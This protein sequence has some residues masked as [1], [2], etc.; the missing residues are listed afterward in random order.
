MGWYNLGYAYFKQQQYSQ[1]VQAFQRYT[2]A[3]SNRAKP[4]SRAL[5]RVGDSYYF[6]R[7]FQEAERYYAQAADANP[8][9]ADYAAF[10]R[11]FVLGL[12]H[13]YQG[14][15]AALDNLMQ[16]YPNSQYFDDALYEEPIT[17]HAQQGARSHHRAAAIGDRFS[18]QS[19]CQSSGRSTGTALL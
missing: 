17:H 4:E 14:K 6:N 10:Q 3:E 5:N 11:A 15:I 2:S 1:A 7:N 12:Q 19:P 9:S 18:T 13:N 16:R 8:A